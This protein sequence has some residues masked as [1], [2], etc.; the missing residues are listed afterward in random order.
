MRQHALAQR[1]RGS[2]GCYLRLISR[3]P[4]R[5]ANPASPRCAP[6]FAGKTKIKTY[7]RKRRPK[8]SS[9]RPARAP[10]IQATPVMIMP[11]GKRRNPYPYSH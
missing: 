10:R 11:H 4:T 8:P 7:P 1:E 6:T 9:A 3:L 5:F 2:A